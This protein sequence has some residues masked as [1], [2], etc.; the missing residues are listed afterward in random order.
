MRVSMHRSRS[1]RS[2][3]GSAAILALAVAFLLL[4]LCG[5]M[6]TRSLQSRG[7]RDGTVTEHR[8]LLVADA[9]VA[10]ALV[11]LTADNAA[12]IGAA[13]N[14]VP[15]AGGSYFATLTDN[16]DGTFTV[17]SSGSSGGEQAAVEAVLAP[18]E[19]G[20]F[21]H[22]VFAGNGS[23]DPGYELEFGGTGTQADDLN[24]DAYSGNDIVVT[25][26]PSLD[27]TLRAT[28]DINGASGEEDV[29]LPIPDLQGMNYAATADFDVEALFNRATY[30]SNAAGG[31]A[32][33]VAQSNPA[34]IFRKN[35]SDR[36]AQTSSTV[37]ADY[38][39][40]DPYQPVTVGSNPD[41]SDAYKFSLTGIGGAPGP[42]S[43]GKVFYIDGNLWMNNKKTFSFIIA[44]SSPTGV[45][46]T[47]VVS[48]NIYLSDN[49]FYK[50]SEMDGIAFIAMKDPGVADS[51]NI[52]FGDPIFGT[53]KT[54]N[55]FTYAEDDFYDNNLDKE[56]STAVS[57]YGNMSAGDQVLIQRDFGTK[58]TKMSF[59]Y[60]G[61]LA[62]G[63]ITMPGIPANAGVGGE[64][65]DV[66]H[67]RRVALP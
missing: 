60:D 11:N 9:G 37:K 53:L 43:N 46:V 38:F 52:Y 2:R 25:G 21:D 47:F 13:E 29:T 19:S 59:N 54:L 20:V 39:L 7:E 5:A 64:G 12:N 4:F 51:G 23:G 61:R 10:H 1:L 14:P 49:L 40:E 15:F 6:L 34:H 3:R 57:L 58:H 33:Q 18:G 63:M 31:S 16:G 66:V 30:R 67:W 55:A 48:G 65:F 8:A 17:V 50:N 42:N 26:T 36:T 35:P 41:G 44:N 27:G 22:A 62:A 45:Q 28:G 32:W 56:G 24:G